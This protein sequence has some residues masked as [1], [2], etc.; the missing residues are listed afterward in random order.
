[1]STRSITQCYDITE[2]EQFMTD[3]IADEKEQQMIQHLEDCEHC[4]FEMNRFAEQDACWAEI[5]EKLIDQHDEWTRDER[6]AMASDIPSERELK[7]IRQLLGPSEN[8]EMLGRLGGFE[9]CGIIGRGS[10]GIVFKALDTRLN[11][12]VAIK[13]LAPVFSNNGSSRRRFEREGR[14]IASVKDP[15]VIPVHTIGEYQG[16]PFIVMQYV[17]EG[18]LQQR[19]DCHGPLSVRD[20]VCVAMQIANGLASAHK[21][22]IIHRDVKPANVLLERGVEGAMVTDFGLARV[23]DEATV[24]HSGSISGTPQYMSPEQ[25]KGDRADQRSD[26]FSL[27]S[28]M[29]AAC[30]GHSPFRAETVFGV[31]KRV[32]ESEPRSIRELNPDVPE[33]LESFINKLHSKDPG[34]RF[35]SAEQVSTCLAEELAYL[36]APT[37]VKQPERPWSDQPAEEGSTVKKLRNGVAICLMSVLAM[38]LGAILW[39]GSG[40][41][42][43]VVEQGSTG[44]INSQNYKDLEPSLLMTMIR[45]DL[46]DQ[47][48]FIKEI[49]KAIPVKSGGQLFLHSNLGSVNVKTHQKSNVEM[50]LVH[51]VSAAD[52][53]TA[54]KIFNALQIR[55][56]LNKEDGI[57]LEMT[58]GVDAAIIANF[59]TTKLTEIENEK[60]EQLKELK[61]VILLK[62]NS[63][64]R[65][66]TF[67]LL[68]PEE[69]NL[70]IHTDAG[71][72]TT[73]E[74]NGW[75][76]LN[77]YAGN[78]E[79]GN[80]TSSARLISKSGQITVANVGN[81]ATIE[82]GAGTIS[83]GQVLGNLTAKTDSGDISGTAVAGTVEASVGTGHIEFGHLQKS[84]SLKT[85]QGNIKVWIADDQ[86]EAI[87]KA[88]K[89]DINLVGQPGGNSKIVCETG[90]IR[91]GFVP[92][93]ELDINAL[94]RLGKISAPFANVNRGRFRHQLNM[95]MIGLNVETQVGN[96]NFES[97]NREQI[98]KKYQ[99]WK[100]QRISDAKLSWGEEVKGLKIAMRMKLGGEFQPGQTIPIEFVVR[101]V[102]A[103]AIQIESPAWRQG[104]SLRIWN[105]KDQL[106]EISTIMY[107]GLQQ[108]QK[109]TL[110]PGS[111]VVLQ[112][113]GIAILSPGSAGL[114]GQPNSP[115]LPAYSAKLKPGDYKAVFTLDLPD[116]H[117]RDREGIWQGRPSTAMVDFVV[118]NKQVGDTD[119]H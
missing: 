112:S 93:L 54:D 22:G 45:Q 47:P 116:V 118:V 89:V 83:M 88:G 1:M 21:H 114:G 113:G 41:S 51:T 19:I 117:R 4:Q 68:I 97:I 16:I 75:A 95:G 17:P 53:A 92:S 58:E 67:E 111:D 107:T 109:I 61:N 11:R 94:C 85:G 108:H 82:T 65:N 30:T 100:E 84:S 26:L 3:E 43:G 38:V 115:N 70:D 28:V 39:D 35:E 101:N 77:T 40:N 72:I 81:D 103:R 24:T 48:K 106:Q 63:H 60:A 66:A 15:N 29:Y 9:I 5:K 6:Q 23:V 99:S 49:E 87:S 102:S 52:E 14:A 25:A 10:A 20:V 46:H 80:I 91:I 44:L 71:Q 36:Q 42:N 33:W 56:Q 37:L 13:M 64:H 73:R 105:N 34:R 57:D 18:S 32:C 69:F 119:D 55:Y 79:T 31:I 90:D 78:I 59:P 98:N 86:V 76:K 74:I 12:F 50:K 96:I 2:F 7:K 104:D 8:P 27:G 62:N 110:E